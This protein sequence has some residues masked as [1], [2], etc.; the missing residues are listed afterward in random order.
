MAKRVLGIDPGLTRCGFGLVSASKGRS[1]GFIEVGVLQSSPDGEL[2]Q[3]IFEI[4]KQVEALLD[5][6]KP[7]AVAIERV[8]S[9]QNLK[10]VVSVANITGVIAYLCLSRGVPV[11][12]FTPTQVKAAVTG[13]GRANKA[14]VSSMVMKILK[15]QEVP[16]TADAND[17][18]AIAITAS[19]RNDFGLESAPMTNAQQKWQDAENAAK[20]RQR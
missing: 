18:L 17:A 2:S 6:L 20:K 19:W 15:L 16:K 14:Q 10:T 7:D 4:G 9:Q 13:S 1:V 3:R 8:F 5:R 12:Y 11:Q